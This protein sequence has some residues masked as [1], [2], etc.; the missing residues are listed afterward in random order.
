MLA[1][2]KE[3]M[4]YGDFK[5]LPRRLPDLQQQ[6]PTLQAFEPTEAYVEVGGSVLP[7]ELRVQLQTRAGVGGSGQ[8]LVSLRPL[9]ALV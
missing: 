8:E 5:L 7:S 1:T 9:R 2:G 4:G 6:E 3:G